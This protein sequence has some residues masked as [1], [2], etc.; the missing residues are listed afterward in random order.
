MLDCL[1]L[2]LLALDQTN[3]VRQFAFAFLFLVLLAGGLL[4]L[5]IDGDLVGTEEIALGVVGETE[6][7][8][9]EFQQKFE[10]CL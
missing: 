1:L 5:W 3:Q 9:A 10:G 8:R 2:F 6:G 4:A 7:Q